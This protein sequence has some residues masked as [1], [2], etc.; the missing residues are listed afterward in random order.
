MKQRFTN[1]IKSR[2]V[3]ALED[4]LAFYC[5]SVCPLMS[6]ESGTWA[7]WEDARGGGGGAVDGVAKSS[8][9]VLQVVGRNNLVP[10]NGEFAGFAGL[11]GAP[12][13]GGAQFVRKVLPIPVAD[14]RAGDILELD[15]F[16]QTGSE[17]TA[18]DFAEI[19]INNVSE[20][21]LRGRAGG[22]DTGWQ[23]KRIV[24]TQDMLTGEELRLALLVRKG[25]DGAYRVLG[26]IDNIRV[27]RAPAITVSSSATSLD[28]GELAS[29]SGT[30]DYDFED[31]FLNLSASTGDLVI[32]EA[33][34]TFRWSKHYP[35][36]PFQE[37]VTITASDSDGL[38]RSETLLVRVD[39]VD[40]IIKGDLSLLT[41]GE[42]ATASREFIVTDVPG[43]RVTLTASSGQIS[44]LGGGRFRW[45]YRAGSGPHLE[46][47]VLTAMDGEGGLSVAEFRVRTENEAPQI[48]VDK[49]PIFVGEGQVFNRSLR[50]ADVGGDQIT[51]EASLGT[52][53]PL[54]EGEYFWHYLAGNG[55]SQLNWTITARDQDGGTSESI[56]HVTI[57]NAPPRVE[58]NKKGDVDGDY[59]SVCWTVS[60]DYDNIAE[61]ILTVVH[62]GI[63]VIQGMS[64]PPSSCFFTST[65]GSGIGA[66]EV[67]LTATDDVATTTAS[68]SLTIQDDDVSAPSIGATEVPPVLHPNDKQTFDWE[69]R[70]ASDVATLVSI[71]R[72]NDAILQSYEPTGSIDLIALIRGRGVG[73]YRIAIIAND[74]DFDRPIDDNL[75]SQRQIRFRFESVRG[76][77]DGDGAIDV[78]DVDFLCA[79]LE[80]QDFEG[81]LDLD[82]NREIGF[83]DVDYMLEEILNTGPGDVNLDGVFD[84]GDLVEI[85]QKGL[86]EDGIEDNAKWSVGDWNCDKE[87]DSSDLVMAF[88]RG[89][90]EY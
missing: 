15:M 57:Q 63:I 2:A 42:G 86:Y 34:R 89:G 28:E 24:V 26:G 8:R 20:D 76:D 23:Q 13:G 75:A 9:D 17:G 10:T 19:R 5:D 16:L 38:S 54:G 27:L 87:F 30:F 74:Q 43:D 56:V 37:S 14:L 22:V 66:F 81:L 39:N 49:S 52:L 31:R 80:K 4:R 62:E 7:G 18:D 90:Y 12:T 61:A 3:E 72:G 44:D 48:F 79:S 84:S 77:I 40:P 29:I 70:D 47:V 68:T 25:G 60:D 78:N 51:L 33:T 45:D 1:G 73:D 85:F 83:S 36:G 58:F 35:N 32:D 46:T 64:A 69:I 55:D 82:G 67:Q 6:L 65:I 41:V 21:P 71:W 53:I 88:Q 59:P 50:V 11:V